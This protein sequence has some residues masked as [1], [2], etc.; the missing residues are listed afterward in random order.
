MA[1]WLISAFAIVFAGQTTDCTVLNFTSAGCEPC[2]QIKPA[3]EQ[4]RGAGWNVQS[5]DVA[6]QPR[7]T[8]LY[9]IQNLPTVVFLCG[10]RE[11]DR[12]VGV[13]PT[14][15][16]HRRAARVAARLGHLAQNTAS[17]TA[18][19]NTTAAP[20]QS[21]AAHPNAATTESASPVQQA[22]STRPQMT[23]RGQSPPRQ[24]PPRRDI[25]AASSV[26]ANAAPTI[27]LQAAIARAQAATVRIRVDEP[28]TTAFGTGTIVDV[29]GQ[30]ALVLTCGHLFRDMTP[31]SQLT[32][33]VFTENGPITLPAQ[34]ID[35]KADKEDI[36]LISFHA[37]FPVQ[38]VPLLPSGQEATLGQAAFSFG[39]D[40]GDDPTRRDTQIAH[41][42]RYLG[43][44]NIE[45]HGAP[46]V[47]RSGGGLFDQQGRLI[48]VCNAADATDD[49]G[50]YAAAGVV[51]A[52]IERLG[53][54]HLFSQSQHQLAN[55]TSTTPTMTASNVM[56]TRPAPT[57]SRPQGDWPTSS[58]VQQA[59][60]L[61][62]GSGAA[63]A[64]NAD[65]LICTIR[66]ASGIER[67]VTIDQP[68]PA[69]LSSIEQHAR[70]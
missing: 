24:S 15:I 38:T 70:R 32:I 49:E 30:E 10:E 39:C 64:V 14:E 7:I 68:D 51:Y 62:G 27:S 56:P 61:A 13:V 52:Q 66:D 36:G 25:E 57:A 19:R 9:N 33:D 5:I 8:E 42:N 55:Q 37:P 59:L 21:N 41:V 43:P 20:V 48:G 6:H 44:A 60:Q 31:G 40:H 16:L 69:L 54:T 34:L 28:N 3:V 22:A 4:L 11:V 35:F 23:V 50:I 26:T 53:L 67:V 12:L 63:T 47:G 65:Q 58:E 46:A 45:I 1:S 18:S 29:H 2:Q 17:T